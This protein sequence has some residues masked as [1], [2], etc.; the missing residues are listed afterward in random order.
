M[1]K[2]TFILEKSYFKLHL[3]GYALPVSVER[4]CINC[5]L[6]SRWGDV[7]RA[8]RGAYSL[9]PKA[10]GTMGL[11]SGQFK[12]WGT[13]GHIC[14]YRKSSAPFRLHPSPRF[15]RIWNFLSYFCAMTAKI[16]PQKEWTHSSSPMTWTM[17]VKIWFTPKRI[18]RSY[19]IHTKAPALPCGTSWL[20]ICSDVHRGCWSLPVY[21]G[22]TRGWTRMVELLSLQRAPKHLAQMGEPCPLLWTHL[23]SEKSYRR[24]SLGRGSL[25]FVEHRVALV[26]SG[27]HSLFLFISLA[28]FP[29]LFFQDFPYFPSWPFVSFCLAILSQTKEA[30][31]QWHKPQPLEVWERAHLPSRIQALQPLQWLKV[32]AL[33]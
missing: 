31:K 10:E 2:L 30:L 17:T 8:L 13:D 20:K 4:I 12:W 29:F 15:L 18:Q 16:R 21:G 1:L 32:F 7:E 19:R 25:G 9:P 11:P 33:N 26:L 5:F 24:V 28:C 6:G 23:P 27:Y 3:G 22:W 14:V